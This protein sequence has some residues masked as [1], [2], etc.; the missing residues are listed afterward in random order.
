M[1]PE[2]ALVRLEVA[3]ARGGCHD[4]GGRVVGAA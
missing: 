2:E 3:R 4:V 1:L